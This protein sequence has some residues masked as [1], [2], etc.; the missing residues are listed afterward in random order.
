MQFLAEFISGDLKII[1]KTSSRRNARAVYEHETCDIG[2]L[3]GNTHRDTP[4][5]R[6]T[7]E[8]DVIRPAF[9]QEFAD[10]LGI[11]IKSQWMRGMRRTSE[12]VHIGQNHSETGGK[13]VGY[14]AKGGDLSTPPVQKD[15]ALAFSLI[16]IVDSCLL[17]APTSK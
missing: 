3:R 14:R 7:Y 9:S 11:I 6:V 4:A 12:P 16:Q 2:I 10:S 17:I 8:N 15:K 13:P 5:E 1:A